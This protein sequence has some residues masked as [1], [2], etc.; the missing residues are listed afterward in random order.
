MSPCSD[1]RPDRSSFGRRYHSGVRTKGYTQANVFGGVPF[2]KA[3][4]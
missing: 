3:G 1:S 2:T 4:A